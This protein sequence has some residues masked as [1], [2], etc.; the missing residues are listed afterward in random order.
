M[1][2]VRKT[3]IYN[4]PEIT[5]FERRAPPYGVILHGYAPPWYIL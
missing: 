2:A 3:L 1:M 5:V 4:F